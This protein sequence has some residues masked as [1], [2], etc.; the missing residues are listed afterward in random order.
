MRALGGEIA[1]KKGLHPIRVE[2]F[3]MSGG[4]G[5]AVSWQGPGV[6]RQPIPPGVLS[7]R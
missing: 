7:H 1:L 6:A 5:L 4:E 2:Y 3:E